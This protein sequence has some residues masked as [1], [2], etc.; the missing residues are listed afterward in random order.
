MCLCTCRWVQVPQGL[1]ASGP[2]WSW[3]DRQLW[4]AQYE[5]QGP[6][7]GPLQA[8]CMLLTCTQVESYLQAQFLIHFWGYFYMNFRI[9]LSHFVKIEVEGEQD[10][11]VGASSCFVSP[12]NEVGPWAHGGGRDLTSISS[13][14]T[15]TACA[16]KQRTPVHTFVIVAVVNLS[17]VIKIGGGATCL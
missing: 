11:S 4:A 1:E 6:N 16:L 5:W 2:P 12:V 10:G 15:S 17:I 13:P 8:Q 9:T 7:S 14:L 3:N